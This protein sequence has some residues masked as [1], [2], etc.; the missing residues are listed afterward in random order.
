MSLRGLDGEAG[1][2]GYEPSVERKDSLRGVELSFPG[3]GG[4]GNELSKADGE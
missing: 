1:G 4:E 3:A 2:G